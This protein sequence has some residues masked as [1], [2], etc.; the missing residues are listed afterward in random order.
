MKIEPREFPPREVM[1]HIS[2]NYLPLV[3]R[4]QLGPVL[5]YRAGCPGADVRRPDAPAAGDL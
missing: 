3:V 1:N 2:A 5:F 4:K